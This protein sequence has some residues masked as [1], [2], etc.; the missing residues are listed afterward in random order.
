MAFVITQPEVLAATVAGYL[1]SLMRS[2]IPPLPMYSSLSRRRQFLAVS[3]LPL[4]QTDRKGG[5]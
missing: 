5:A 3:V 2:Q 1:C 4:F